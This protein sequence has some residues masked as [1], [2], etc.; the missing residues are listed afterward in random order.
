[1]NINGNVTLGTVAGTKPSFSNNGL[2][3]IGTGSTLNIVNQVTGIYSLADA[4]QVPGSIVIDGGRLNLTSVKDQSYAGMITGDFTVKNGGVL[5]VVTANTYLSLAS[6][7]NLVAEKNTTITADKIIFSYN[8][9][10]INFDT[11]KNLT[12]GDGNIYQ[13]ELTVI[14]TINN[15]VV[16]ASGEFYVFSGL[17]FHNYANAV[18]GNYCEI[19]F[20]LNGAGMNIGTVGALSDTSY[21]RIIFN[22][23]EAGLVSVGNFTSE[24]ITSGTFDIGK[25]TLNLVAYDKNGNLLDGVWS[26][27]ENG[28]LFNSALVPEPAEFAAIFGALAIALAAYRRR[29]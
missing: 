26:V 10:L 7:A 1:M 17:K 5:N 4:S 27:D 19:T 18:V 2:V 11:A 14:R 20:D 24:L 9:D 13:K 29:R 12:L 21:G 16:L 6:S 22:D 8:S 15:T 28:Y 3:T 23:F 25:A